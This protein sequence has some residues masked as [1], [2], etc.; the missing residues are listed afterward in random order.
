[1][2]IHMRSIDSMFAPK[3]T[4]TSWQS[5]K[6]LVSTL[7][8]FSN[9]ECDSFEI[10]WKKTSSLQWLSTKKLWQRSMIFVEVLICFPYFYQISG[11]R[12]KISLFSLLR[13][14]LVFDFFPSF[15]IPCSIPLWFP[16]EFIDNAINCLIN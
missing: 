14:L 11:V 15:L 7:F 10:K 5:S 6:K 4:M 13:R 1:M 9:F 12:N 16:F 2:G 8:F 3:T